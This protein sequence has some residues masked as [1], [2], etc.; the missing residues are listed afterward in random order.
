[1]RVNRGLLG[2]GVFFI[3]LGAVP[4]A[5]SNGLVDPA[6][7]RRAWQLWPLILIGV[8]LGLV[9]ERPR[10]ALVGGL[11]IAVTLGLIGGAV[12]AGTATFPMGFTACGGGANGGAAFP[13]QTGSLVDGGG[14]RLDINCG[15][16]LVT[17]AAGTSWAVG[18]TSSD[19]R[20]P[21]IVASN[22]N[23]AVT[24]RAGT[25]Y[26]FGSP[27]WHWDVTL[28]QTGTL[29]VDLAVNAGSA[30]A[31]LAGVFLETVNVSVNAGDATLELGGANGPGRLD[32]SVN[33]GSMAVALPTA[34]MQGSVT[35][36]A[37][38]AELCVPSGVALRLR[39]GGDPLGS[40]DLED[41]GLVHDGDT[42]TTPGFDTAP[43]QIELELSANLGSIGLNPEGGCE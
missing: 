30:K 40:Y 35:V 38:S 24:T 12:L 11:V 8:G 4:L 21:E 22:G 41:Q 33:A 20:S 36:N 32:A 37:G 14:I 7:I 26:P 25:D 15:E 28:P 27:G 29:N 31:S 6:V 34:S 39:T 13:T 43:V 18:G 9:L 10:L 16:L 5:V 3:V 19:G 23:L 17:P 1:M 2:W 42:W